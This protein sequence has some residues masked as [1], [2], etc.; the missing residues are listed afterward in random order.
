VINLPMERHSIFDDLN[1]AVV[2]RLTGRYPVEGLLAVDQRPILG[3]TPVPELEDLFHIFPNP[4]QRRYREVVR[5]ALRG[6]KLLPHINFMQ[7]HWPERTPI[8]E[9]RELSI[10]QLANLP[11]MSKRAAVQVAELLA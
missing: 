5:R 2:C 7:A 3:I 8:D 11:Q 6:Y 9:L 1:K 10:E 4:D